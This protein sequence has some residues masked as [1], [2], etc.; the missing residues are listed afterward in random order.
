MITTTTIC[1]N[2]ALWLIIK[3]CIISIILAIAKYNYNK[4]STDLQGNCHAVRTAKED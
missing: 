1:I 3:L 2:L 4:S